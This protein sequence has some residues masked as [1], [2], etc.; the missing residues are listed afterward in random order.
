MGQDKLFFRQKKPKNIKTTQKNTTDKN[1]DKYNKYVFA[2]L[3]NK[4]WETEK[5]LVSEGGVGGG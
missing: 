3:E 4:L 1:N 5:K 2:T